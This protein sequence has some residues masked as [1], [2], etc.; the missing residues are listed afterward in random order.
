MICTPASGL[1]HL[2]MAKS[3]AQHSLRSAPL[4]YSAPKGLSQKPHEVQTSVL[5][6]IEII[7][8]NEGYNE[9]AMPICCKKATIHCGGGTAPSPTKGT[10]NRH[11]VTTPSMRDQ[12]L[13][14]RASRASGMSKPEE[15]F[16]AAAA[17]AMTGGMSAIWRVWVD[18]PDWCAAKS[19]KMPSNGR[20]ARGTV[21]SSGAW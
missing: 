11:H 13:I 14:N 6:L 18:A 15:C 21:I 10:V 20:R 17:S 9:S 3:S 5:S 8:W 12:P 19:R 16:Q 2:T 7:Q 1:F 4:L